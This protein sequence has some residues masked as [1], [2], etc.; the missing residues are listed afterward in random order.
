M[1]CE[2][3]DL[4]QSRDG[5]YVYGDAGRREIS[6]TKGVMG[7][8][9]MDEMWACLAHGK[10]ILHDGWWGLATL[11]VCVAILESARERREVGLTHQRPAAL[12]Q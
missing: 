3:G 8:L 12:Y 10:P 4:R 11:E 1:S 2:Q 6:G 9:E 7:T 5:V